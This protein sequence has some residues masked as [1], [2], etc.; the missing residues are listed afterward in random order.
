[1]AKIASATP[2]KTNGFKD[3]TVS[4]ISLTPKQKAEVEK[5]AY[6]YFVE[7]GYEHGHDQEDWSR[8]EAA[9]RARLS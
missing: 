3:L 9:V 2:K 4:N 7:R 1:M 5:L 8:A 6:Q